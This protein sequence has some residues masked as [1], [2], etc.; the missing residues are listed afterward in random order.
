VES[1]SWRRPSRGFS[2]SVLRDLLVSFFGASGSVR[3]CHFPLCL[4]AVAPPSMIALTPS[5]PHSLSFLCF[6]TSS[7]SLHTS[8]FFYLFLI[9]FFSLGPSAPGTPSCPRT[10]PIY[11]ILPPSP[12]SRRRLLSFPEERK[13]PTANCGGSFSFP[14]ANPGRV[15]VF[16][17]GHASPISHAVTRGSFSPLRACFALFVSSPPRGGGRWRHCT[18]LPLCVGATH[19]RVDLSFIAY[20]FS[21]H[22]FH[23]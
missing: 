9:F 23:N 14:S 22:S 1:F 16:R 6:R 13:L 7:A 17:R 18:L 15:R 19:E 8:P 3:W 5:P 10:I 2:L 11:F 21:S 4:A 20:D 12:S